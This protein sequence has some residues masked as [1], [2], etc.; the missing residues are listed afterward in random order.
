MPI[1]SV[2]DLFDRLLGARA[3]HEVRGILEE[4][5]DFADVEIDQPFGPLKLQ[6]HA[7]GDNLSNISSIGLGT[8][9]GRSL[10]ERIT[11]GIDAILEARKPAG[12]TP[13]ESSR[14]AAKQWFGRPISGPDEG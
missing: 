9:P 7:F 6:W 10:T 12:V 1:T 5:G 2:Q 11:N 13:P 8:K 4:L 3:P 14:L